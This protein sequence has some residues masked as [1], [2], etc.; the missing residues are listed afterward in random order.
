MAAAVGLR[1][2]AA[3][4]CSFLTSEIA[5]NDPEEV[6]LDT[7]PP[8]L[9]H[10]DPEIWRTTGPVYDVDED[11]NVLG[12]VSSSCDGISSF[13]L[14]VEATDDRSELSEMRA[15]V[16]VV[17]GESPID[18]EGGAW[19]VIG[20]GLYFYW[21]ESAQEGLPPLSFALEIRVVDRAGNESEP[22]EVHVEAPGRSAEEFIRV[23][24]APNEE[25]EVL[26]VTEAASETVE[27]PDAPETPDA[28]EAPAIV[29]AA[30]E[31]QLDPS[32]HG[33]SL[34]PA[35]LSPR[36]G[37]P[38]SLATLGAFSLIAW[39]RRGTGS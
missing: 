39:R 6:G 1:A 5:P 28:R 35:P 30:A 31:D 32:R 4:A 7:I 24:S 22:L 25:P 20:D 29:E 38:L 2:P 8:K 12:G 34:P 26:P 3:D 15:R 37:L 14:T 19:R 16:T 18:F 23:V 21:V 13:A 27:T 9:A 11:G 33:C 36:P 17:A 10:V